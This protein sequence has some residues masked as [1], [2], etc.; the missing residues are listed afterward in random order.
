[1]KEENHMRRANLNDLQA[2]ERIEQSATQLYYENGFA[3]EDVQPRTVEDLLHLLKET[4]VYLY[5]K[6]STPIGYMSF[7]QTGSYRHLEEFSVHRDAQRQGIGKAMMRIYLQQDLRTVEREPGGDFQYYSLIVF[8]KA[9]WA[10]SAYKK[11][12]FKPIDL[13]SPSLPE[14]NRLLNILEAEKRAGLDLDQRQLMV[15]HK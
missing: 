3:K 15:K 8:K 4:Q 6:S 9:Y 12:G 2:L 13:P 14:Q 7:Y 11:V 5:E 1:V 10:V